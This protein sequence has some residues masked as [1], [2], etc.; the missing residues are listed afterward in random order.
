MTSMTTASRGTASGG[1]AGRAATSPTR[2][3]RPAFWAD[4]RFVIGIVLVAAS[5]AAVWF[6]VAAARQT[7]PVLAAAHA[8]VPG[9][10]ITASDVTVVDVALGQAGDAYVAPGALD[11]GVVALRVVGAGE[12]LPA[13]AAGPAA[14]SDRT[15]V[16][17]RSSV[18]VPAGVERGAV[19]ELWETPPA[20]EPGAYEA[21]RVLVADAVVA[22]VVSEEGVMAAGGASLELVIDRAHVSAVLAA[23]AAG[24]VLSAV[25]GVGEAPESAP[26]EDAQE[27][28]EGDA[29]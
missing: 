7:V 5:I 19:V 15:S 11:E 28:G 13:A 16:V 18:D 26:A 29:E 10:T 2:A 20:G 23:V 1:R 9:Q 22:R 21:P 17:V 3:A 24:S 27:P 14:L 6:V 4:A 8:L 25:P 12:L